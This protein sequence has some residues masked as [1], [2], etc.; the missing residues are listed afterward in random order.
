[1]VLDSSFG[2]VLSEL[3]M[4]LLVVASGLFCRVLETSWAAEALP[5]DKFL[6]PPCFFP[7]PRFS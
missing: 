6:A 2:G 1:M 5:S 4:L 3:I 7:L